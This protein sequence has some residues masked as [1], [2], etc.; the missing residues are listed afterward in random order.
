MVY[1]ILLVDDDQINL[2]VLKNYSKSY[3]KVKFETAQNGLEAIRCIEEGKNKKVFFD[4]IFLDCNMP[5][6]NGFEC[7]RAVRQRIEDG[8]IPSVVIVALTGDVTDEEKWLCF[9]SGMNDFLGKPIT[10]QVFKGVLEKY[11]QLI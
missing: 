5:V 6:M 8:F 11:L 10:R 2:L 7:A 3:G 9:Q 1:N 4:L